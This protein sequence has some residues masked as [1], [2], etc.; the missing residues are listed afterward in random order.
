QGHKPV[1]AAKSSKPKHASQKQR[2]AAQKL[3]QLHFTLD[4][5]VLRTCPLCEL[6]Y[7]RAAPDDEALHRSHCAR[8]RRGMEW[9]RD[10]E[11][12]ARATE[13]ASGL[14]LKGEQWRHVRGR[15]VSV[16]L[17]VG[18]K[19]GA[20]LGA[21]LQTI[22]LA[23]SSP[24]LPPAALKACKAYLFLVPTPA[25][26]SLASTR[27]EK[28]AGCVIAQRIDTAMRNVDPTPPSGEAPAARQDLVAVDLSSGLYVHPEPLPTAMGIP[29]LFVSSTY[30]RCGIA[31]QLLDAAARTF[32]HS[33]PLDPRKGEVA[34]TQ[35]TSSGRAVMLR[36]GQGAVRIYDE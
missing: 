28:I 3:T 12:E 33:C 35:P 22:N 4:T 1:K 13:I 36:W 16:R 24:P 30:R 6:S 7:T 2:P 29:R 17:D 25:S 19:T 10:E 26:S 23:L 34:F 27:R 8:V 31:M 9:G 18:G 21:L 11:R 5:S 14:R 15:I 20:K 32:I